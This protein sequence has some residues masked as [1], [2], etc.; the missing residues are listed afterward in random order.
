MGHAVENQ[1]LVCNQEIDDRRLQ[2]VPGRA[3][4]D[5]FDVMYKF[6]A[7]ETDR[8]AGKARQ[9]GQSDGLESPHDLLDHSQPVA[10]GP[11][12]IGAGAGLDSELF[13]DFAVLDDINVLALLADD[14]AGI[15]AHEG[16]TANVFA[17]FDGFE[18]KGFALPAN[19]AIGGERSFQIRQN[20]AR[21]RDEIALSGQIQKFRLRWI[22][23]SFHSH[24]LYS[25]R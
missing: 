10:D 13:G 12:A 24:K 7:D 6:V 16:I 15:A 3:R 14:G 4:H 22:I 23:D 9:S 19:L 8:P 1:K 18:K 21:D 11:G 17:A 25:I 5:R 20:P 2:V